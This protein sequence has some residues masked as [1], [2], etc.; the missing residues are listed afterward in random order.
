[1]ETGTSRRGRAGARKAQELCPVQ[2]LCGR[3]ARDD[4]GSSTRRRCNKGTSVCS[5]PCTCR[6]LHVRRGC[7]RYPPGERGPARAPRPRAAEATRKPASARHLQHEQ[8]PGQEATLTVGHQAKDSRSLARPGT[9]LP[10]RA[11]HARPDPSAARAS[12]EVQNL[13]VPP[14]SLWPLAGFRRLLAQAHHR[15]TR[16]GRHG[17]Q[18]PCLPARPTR[19]LP[20]DSGTGSR[21]PPSSPGPGASAQGRPGSCSHPSAHAVPVRRA[22]SDKR[23]GLTSSAH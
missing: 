17:W 13:W 4:P 12:P 22:L 8:Q 3:S 5:R 23:L 20:A 1:M 2:R 15:L 19:P 14:P 7:G 6:A 21:Q 16:T 10:G 11:P 9:G 18:C